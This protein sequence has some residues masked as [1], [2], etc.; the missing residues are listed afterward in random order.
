MSNNIGDSNLTHGANASLPQELQRFVDEDAIIAL[1]DLECHC[2]NQGIGEPRTNNRRIC[3]AGLTILDSRDMIQVAQSNHGIGDRGFNIAEKFRSYEFG[4]IEAKHFPDHRCR[5]PKSKNPAN[6]CSVG[7]AKD[8]K[9]G[10]VTWINRQDLGKTLRTTIDRSAGIQRDTADNIITAN[11]SH[12]RV[13]FIFF[14]DK[15]D[16]KWLQQAG[17]RLENMYPNCGGIDIQQDSAG[18]IITAITGKQQCGAADLYSYLGI[19]TSYRH[20]GG[21]DTVYEM[22]AF[23]AEKSLTASQRQ[24]LGLR[25]SVLPAIWAD[26]FK[27]ETGRIASVVD[28]VRQDNNMAGHSVPEFQAM[29]TTHAV[30]ATGTHEVSTTEPVMESTRQQTLKTSRAPGTPQVAIDA[31]TDMIIRKCDEMKQGRQWRD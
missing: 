31:I 7:E 5:S 3:E 23:I 30:P 10:N 16:R 21:N 29:A 1:I 4:I 26:D 2:W 27:W 18:Q 19:P 20:N 8:F 17:I 13:Y 11:G 14:D 9:F 15:Q 28:T 12:R 6:W 25:L 24:R 22:Q